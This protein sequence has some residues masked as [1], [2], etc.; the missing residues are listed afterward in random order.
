MYNYGKMKRDLCI[1][2]DDLVIAVRLLIDC[3][4]QAEVKGKST[5]ALIDSKSPVAA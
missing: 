5:L 4:P 1:Y 2:I 3:I